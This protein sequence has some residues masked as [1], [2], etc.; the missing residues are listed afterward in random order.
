MGY[1]TPIIILIISNI[2]YN[3]C[4]KNTPEGINP[5]AMLVVVYII[6][7]IASLILYHVLEPDANLIGE[8]KNLNWAGLL[9]GLCVV[10]MEVGNIYMYKVGWQV[11]VGFMLS[12]TVVALALFVIGILIYKEAITVTKVAGVIVCLAGL[13]LINK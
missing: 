2:A 11:S 9:M 7:A 10:G 3:L 8:Y 5:L 13:Y 1:V 6:G 12:S 4:S